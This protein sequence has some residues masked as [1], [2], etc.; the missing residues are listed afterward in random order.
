[1]EKLI[2]TAINDLEKAVAELK[3]ENKKKFPDFNP[4]IKKIKDILRFIKYS[5]ILK[6]LWF[7]G[8]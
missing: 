5:K 4:G 1:M 6:R 3:E 2:D 8:F 7:N